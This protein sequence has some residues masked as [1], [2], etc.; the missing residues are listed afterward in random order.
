MG[1]IREETNPGKDNWASMQEH[2][3][4]Q[5]A[6]L[7]KSAEAGKRFKSKKMVHGSEKG[8]AGVLQHPD[9]EYH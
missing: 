2:M 6:P 7:D 8:T 5:Y 4:S 9:L 3:Q 1:R